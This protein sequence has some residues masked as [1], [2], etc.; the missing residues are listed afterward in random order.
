MPQAT[1]PRQW[2]GPP[3]GWQSGEPG[4]PSQPTPS[5]RLP[6][7]GSWS[8]GRWRSLSRLRPFATSP[9]YIEP[10]ERWD[11]SPRDSLDPA[12]QELAGPTLEAGE[13][14]DLLG[15]G[16]RLGTVTAEDPAA[17]YD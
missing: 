3:D 13:L 8:R 1:A 5:G 12:A 7:S 17:T 2:C 11:T 15:T 9:T 6:G 4:R 14:G 10:V 16:T